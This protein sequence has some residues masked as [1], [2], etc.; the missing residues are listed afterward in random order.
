MKK[1]ICLFFLVQVSVVATDFYYN[2]TLMQE[3]NTIPAQ[4]PTTSQILKYKNALLV[5][6]KL[7]SFENFTI[8]IGFELD[9]TADESDP[10]RDIKTKSS[11]TELLYTLQLNEILFLDFGKKK[12]ET[13]NTFFYSP[14]DFFQSSWNPSSIIS[15]NANDKLSEGV[16]LL[17]SEYFSDNF[18]INVI[19]MPSVKYAKS[20][21]SFQNLT[22]EQDDQYLITFT[23]TSEQNMDTSL[24]FYFLDEP[25]IGL[26]NNTFWGE[27][28]GL[29]SSIT[30]AR[31]GEMQ[32][33]KFDNNNSIILV[34]EEK[35]Y[36]Y[37]IVIGS[38]ITFDTTNNLIIEYLY[39]S[40]SLSKDDYRNLI[41]QTRERWLQTLSP[42]SFEALN[43]FDAF[44]LSKDYLFLRYIKKLNNSFFLE[45]MHT[46]NL[47]DGSGFILN[48]V[49]HTFDNGLFAVSSQ[50]F[51]G[52][53][54]SEFGVI[55]L[56]SRLF[57]E[58]ELTW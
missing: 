58:M 4:V 52:E 45:I 37:D 40:Y 19:F 30:I 49:G 24:F 47:T 12:V 7:D 11:L 46:G 27:H 10:E 48:K 20:D 1:Y 28:I 6:E 25:I 14:T 29:Y 50:H 31:Q 16:W 21:N 51:H 9:Y 42:I 55:P 8:D 43:S 17:G 56:E 18:S 22:S 13:S 34:N 54:N 44:T 33:V 26:N 38:N 41:R 36:P 23:T 15:K 3:Q 32:S 53:E 5:N 39:H 57:I 2:S 35:D